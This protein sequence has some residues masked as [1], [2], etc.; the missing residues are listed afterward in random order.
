MVGKIVVTAP[1]GNRDAH[2]DFDSEKE[3][4]RGSLLS[5]PRLRYYVS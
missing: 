3:G 1:G 5:A 2:F 4:I